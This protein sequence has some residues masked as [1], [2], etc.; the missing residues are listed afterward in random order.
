MHEG[1]ARWHLPGLSRLWK[2][3]DA[4]C[5]NASCSLACTLITPTRSCSPPLQSGSLLSSAGT[6]LLAALAALPSHLLPRLVHVGRQV[7]LPPRSAAPPLCPMQHR[8]RQQRQPGEQQP[9]D[10]LCPL[11]VPAGRLSAHRMISYRL[12]IAGLYAV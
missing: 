8:Q 4:D 10:P 6:R 5:C 7:S 11:A 3:W 2:A 1:W 12:R 9:H